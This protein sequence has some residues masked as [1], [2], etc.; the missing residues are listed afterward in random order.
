[1][2]ILG[3][4][5]FKLA[6]AMKYAEVFEGVSFG[7]EAF[8]DIVQTQSF[9]VFCHHGAWTK[10]LNRWIIIFKPRTKT[11]P[12]KCQR[13]VR[14]WL[15]MVVRQFVIS[16][17]IFEGGING[18]KPFSPHGHNKANYLTDNGVLCFSCWFA[19]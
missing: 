10:N 11:T 13:Y 17:S 9:D 1:M 5:D 14:L 8:L 12:S 15:R 16:A 4:V 18:S 3:S 6:K 7:D 19:L 2:T